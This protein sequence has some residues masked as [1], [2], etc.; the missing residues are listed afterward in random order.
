MARW[1]PTRA[2]RSGPVRVTKPDGTIK[3]EPALSPRDMARMAELESKNRKKAA[4]KI[5]SRR[6]KVRKRS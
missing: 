4:A 5:A 1:N 2:S 3:V 6:R